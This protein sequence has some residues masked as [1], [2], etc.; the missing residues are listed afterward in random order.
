MHEKQRKHSGLEHVQQLRVSSEDIGESEKHIYNIQLHVCSYV[1]ASLLHF[2]TRIKVDF[3]KGVAG[4][5]KNYIRVPM[6]KMSDFKL[7]NANLFFRF[8]Y[9]NIV[10]K[11]LNDDIFLKLK[12][13]FS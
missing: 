7:K 2:R 1:N 8:N 11:D 6:Y 3:L 9:I 12:S 5:I 4:F 13:V 10:F